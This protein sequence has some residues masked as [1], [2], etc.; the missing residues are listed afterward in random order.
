[1]I[2][3]VVSGAERN[4]LVGSFGERRSR[5][6]GEAL[7]RRLRQALKDDHYVSE[8][9]GRNRFSSVSNRVWCCE[10]SSLFKASDV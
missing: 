3:A 2:R 5:L 7:A 8:A 6:S 9:S 10:L 1:M 4:L